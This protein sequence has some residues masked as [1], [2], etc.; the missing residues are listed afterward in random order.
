MKIKFVGLIFSCPLGLHSSDCIFS[1]I[2]ETKSIRERLLYWEK[3]TDQQ[4]YDFIK[5]HWECF[6]KNNSILNDIV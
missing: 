4:I 3:M 6:R 2:R 1:A 5:V